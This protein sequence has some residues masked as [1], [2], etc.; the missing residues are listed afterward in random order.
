MPFSAGLLLT[1]HPEV[2]ERTFSVACPYLQKAPAGALPDNRNISA[3][4]SRRM[5]SL[6]LWLTL[7][8]H[9][10]VAYEELINRQMRLAQTFA[11]WVAMSEY[12]ELAA[13]Q[14][15]PILNLRVP[16]TDK[17][18]QELNALHS[19][20]VDEVNRDGQRWI[21][22][23]TV[24]GQSVIR[25]M[26]ISYLTEERHLKDLQASLL[27]ACCAQQ[28]QPTSKMVPPL[29]PKIPNSIHLTPAPLENLPPA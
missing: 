15:L 5:N 26:V 6:K 21:S 19:L 27:A 18:P 12:F 14:V 22:T 24:N 11:E 1:R 16:A 2:L 17:T 8:V 29:Q 3:Q 13:P 10:R 4:W 25:T 7:R 28:L 23:A 20:I 9:G